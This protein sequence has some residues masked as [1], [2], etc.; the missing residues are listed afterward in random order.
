MSRLPDE[1]IAD[2]L[3]GQGLRV[4]P[5]RRAVWAA[6]EN[7]RAGHLTAHE[8]LRRA[9]RRVPEVSRATVY[10]ALSEFVA[11]G[12]LS[13]I[14]GTGPQLYDP[15]VAPHHHF[16]CRVCHRLVDVHPRDADRVALAEPGYVVERTRVVFEG[17][18]PS[19][20]AN[21]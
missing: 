11:A 17:V 13:A 8:V 15:N 16:R 10:N 2:L 1:R 14:E 5:Q 3:R 9:R 19:C 21:R 18:C 12:L 4:T 6:F 7:G 20:A